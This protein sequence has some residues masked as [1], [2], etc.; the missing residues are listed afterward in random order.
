MIWQ[1]SL[2]FHNTLLTRRNMPMFC[3]KCGKQLN[4]GAS[5]CPY[6]GQKISN[7]LAEIM[8]QHND[9]IDA[10]KENQPGYVSVTLP[11][12]K[13][14]GKILCCIAALLII[15]GVYQVLSSDYRWNVNFYNECVQNQLNLGTS[16]YSRNL[17][18]TYDGWISEYGAKI[19]TSR[20]KAVSFSIIGLACGASGLY[21][22]KKDS[23]KRRQV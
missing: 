21:L 11:R 1:M 15:I 14:V 4:E 12:M 8:E 13:V 9:A 23:T 2:Q 5:Y 17:S 6:C 20:V 18:H 10:T 22:I 16:S 19:R 7:S 3:D